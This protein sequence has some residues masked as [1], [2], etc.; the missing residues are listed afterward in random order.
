MSERLTSGATRYEITKLRTLETQA[1]CNKIIDYLSQLEASLAEAELDSKRLDKLLA[2]GRL[3][4]NGTKNPKNV[5]IYVLEA[6]D[7]ID[8]YLAMEEPHE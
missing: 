5:I 8:A 1:G 3:R 6:R 4:C 7:D 2:T